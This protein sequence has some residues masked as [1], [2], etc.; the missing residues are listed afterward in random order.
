[1]MG[2][3]GKNYSEWVSKMKFFD[4]FSQ[5]FQFQTLDFLWRNSKNVS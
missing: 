3:Q 2:N 1:M 5:I 4:D